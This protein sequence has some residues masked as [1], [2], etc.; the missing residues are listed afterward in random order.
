MQTPNMEKVPPL[1]A[2]ELLSTNKDRDPA[3]AIAAIL[4]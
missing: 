2:S 4:A 3:Q 1:A